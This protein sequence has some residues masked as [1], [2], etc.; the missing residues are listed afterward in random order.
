M[1]SRSAAWHLMVAAWRRAA[2]LDPDYGLVQLGK[3]LALMQEA[4]RLL[5]AAQT[6]PTGSAASAQAFR[7]A[8]EDLLQAR[9]ALER[10]AVLLPDNPMPRKLLNDRRNL[11]RDTHLGIE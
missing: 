8:A 3:G 9:P 1:T 5:S 7:L 4:L 2:E 6:Q 11:I 10:A